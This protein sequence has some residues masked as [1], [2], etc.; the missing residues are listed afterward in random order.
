MKI[1]SENDPQVISLAVDFLRAG[2]II[3]FAT[4]TVY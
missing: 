1:I 3:S 4:D 2:K